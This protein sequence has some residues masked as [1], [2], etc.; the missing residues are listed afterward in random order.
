MFFYVTIH[1]YTFMLWSIW[2]ITFVD[3]NFLFFFS[4]SFLIT[5]RRKKNVYIIR[6]KRDALCFRSLLHRWKIR[7]KKILINTSSFVFLFICYLQH[8][9]NDD[10]LELKGLSVEWIKEPQVFFAVALYILCTLK[11]REITHV[12]HTIKKRWEEKK[13]EKE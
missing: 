12:I 2:C 9:I 1:L 3:L 4:F 10:G 5:K 13:K 6:V 8:D 11:R 7:V